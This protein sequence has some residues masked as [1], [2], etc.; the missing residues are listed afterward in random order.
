MRLAPPRQR[1]SI[2]G[3]L[4]RGINPAAEERKEINYSYAVGESRSDFGPV[5]VFLSFFR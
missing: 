2:N 5:F 4:V 1:A 3:A